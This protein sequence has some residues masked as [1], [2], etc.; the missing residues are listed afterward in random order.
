MQGPR[1]VPR[2]KLAIAFPPSAGTHF[3][4]FAVGPT[5]YAA[6]P[7]SC[8]SVREYVMCVPMRESKNPK[9]KPGTEE[10]C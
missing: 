3:F 10:E 1:Q 7:R 2:T 9:G 4:D 6:S 5:N 8:G